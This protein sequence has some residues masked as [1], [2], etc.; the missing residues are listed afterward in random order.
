MYNNVRGLG[1][2]EAEFLS[3]ISMGGGQFAHARAVEFWGSRET[4]SRRLYLLLKKNWIARLERGKYIVIPLE[5]GVERQWSGDPF[6]LA[7][8]LVTPAAIAY[9]TALRHWG[10]AG[11]REEPVYI[12]TTSRKNATG[13]TI[14]GKRFEYVTVPPAKFFG[15]VTEVRSGIPV[16]VT[17]REKTLLDACDDVERAG[18][19]RAVTTAVRRAA[20][21]ISWPTLDGYALRFPNRSALK[22]LGYLV[23]S[24]ARDISEEGNRV[25]DRWRANLSAGVVP[26]EPGLPAGGRIST[27][28]RVRFNVEG[29]PRTGPPRGS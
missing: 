26:L 17:D 25:L 15:H 7:S 16:M 24:E 6:A 5:A 1:R 22:R 8:S 19:I 3:L 20:A 27:R 12:Q 23:E 4:A 14:L 9:G 21:E 10:W 29:E 13:K 2:R 28:W 18:G 11:V